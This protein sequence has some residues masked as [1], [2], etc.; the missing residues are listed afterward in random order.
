MHKFWIKYLAWLIDKT[1]WGIRD[2][3]CDMSHQP[4][5]YPFPSWKPC[6]WLQLHTGEVSDCSFLG[7]SHQTDT[8]LQVTSLI[9]R[10]LDIKALKL[11]V[12][13]LLNC[14]ADMMLSVLVSFS[15]GFV[16]DAPLCSCWFKLSIKRVFWPSLS[17]GLTLK[18]G[19]PKSLYASFLNYEKCLQL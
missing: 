4:F 10:L 8:L 7:I 17:I 15:T 6:L 9:G 11:E 19:S 14:P 3:S 5:S 16:H 18:D 2:I 1:T 13:V 12:L